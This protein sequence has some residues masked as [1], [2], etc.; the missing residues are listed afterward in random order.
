MGHV[1]HRNADAGVA[2]LQVW[3]KEL[4][5]IFPCQ[6]HYFI[7]V[8]RVLFHLPLH[9]RRPC[10]AFSTHFVLALFALFLK[11][12]QPP[13][14]AALFCGIANPPPA[15]RRSRNA[16]IND[17]ARDSFR[18]RSRRCAQRRGGCRSA[19]RRG[20][21]GGS[22]HETCAKKTKLCAAAKPNLRRASP[23]RRR[24]QDLKNSPADKTVEK[25]TEV[26]ESR[27]HGRGI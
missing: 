8:R 9:S 11:L 10:A 19:N 21:K 6:H 7:G 12:P 2:L 26:R 3:D 15:N 23:K 5:I 16:E 20:A 27:P 17:I 22:A 24:S 18:R 25:L 4:V 14:A 1:F 13:G